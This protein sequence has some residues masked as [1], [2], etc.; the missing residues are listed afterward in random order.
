MQHFFAAVGV[1]DVVELEVVTAERA[2][3]RGVVSDALA[4]VARDWIACQN[5]GVADP[6]PDTDNTVFTLRGLRRGTATLT[7]Y[8]HEQG[9]QS[10][11]YNILVNGVTKATAVSHSTGPNGPMTSAT[12][13]FETDGTSD[14]VIMLE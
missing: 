5:G 9:D 6:G 2:L 1:G 14:Y 13:M 7:T 4:D 3:N 10:G 12:F 11:T 8:H